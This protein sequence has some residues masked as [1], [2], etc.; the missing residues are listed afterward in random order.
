[1]D[2]RSMWF[3]GEKHMD[4]GNRGWKFQGVA[5]AYCEASQKI[6]SGDNSNTKGTPEPGETKYSVDETCTFRGTRD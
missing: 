3:S 4:Q 5:I 6:L 2:A 1:M